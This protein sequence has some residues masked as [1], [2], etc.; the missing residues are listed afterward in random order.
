MTGIKIA[1]QLSGCNGLT[2]TGLF[3]GIVTQNHNR[4]KQIFA[5]HFLSKSVS[6]NNLNTPSGTH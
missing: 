1:V 5:E 6:T 4:G 2:C 3:S